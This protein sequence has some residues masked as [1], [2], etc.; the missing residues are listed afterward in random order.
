VLLQLGSPVAKALVLG[1]ERLPLPPDSHLGFLEGLMSA[2]QHLREVSQRCFR[3]DARS[4]WS[5]KNNPRTLRSWRQNRA[6]RAP[7]PATDGA[8]DGIAAVGSATA[9]G[10]IATSGPQL[11][12]GNPKALPRW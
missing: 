4:E 7:T 2:G 1:L 6:G 3:F 9:V 11:E 12:L 5:P 10:S 8:S